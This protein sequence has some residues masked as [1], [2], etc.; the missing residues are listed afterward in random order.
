MIA[1]VITTVTGLEVLTGVI[2]SIGCYGLLSNTDL[3]EGP[4]AGPLFFE[5]SGV[6]FE[7]HQP[8]S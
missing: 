2:E 4:L 8:S 1:E 3:G 7:A 5:P 6:R